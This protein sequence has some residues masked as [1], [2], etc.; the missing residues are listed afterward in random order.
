MNVASYGKLTRTFAWVESAGSGITAE[1]IQISISRELRASQ[2][3]D[4]LWSLLVTA[5]CDE[6]PPRGDLY[7][8]PEGN[9]R[10]TDFGTMVFTKMIQRLM[11]AHDWE[12]R[13]PWGLSIG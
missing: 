7:E 6:E 9:E 8:G 10:L 3:N 4:G 13:T 2:D 12:T 5:A 11:D 1:D